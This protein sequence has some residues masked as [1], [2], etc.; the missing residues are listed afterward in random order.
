ATLMRSGTIRFLFASFHNTLSRAQG[1]FFRERCKSS[2]VG[3]SWL[4]SLVK[5]FEERLHDIDWHRKDDRGILF[6]AD[7]SQ[8]LQITQ[9]HG[10]RNAPEDLCGVYKGLRRLELGFRVD[11]LRTPVTFRLRLFSNGAYHVLSKLDSSDLNVAHL[12]SPSFGLRVQDA[13]DVGTEFLSF[14]KHLV[15]LMLPQHSAQRRLR[16]HVCG[17]KVGLNLNDR[18]FGIDDIEVEHRVNLH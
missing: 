15:E 9:L 16:E 12:D 13:L 7:L 14:R 5:K 1:E 2:A 8:R 4:A 6:G 17:G 18:S 3:A 10:G 11:D